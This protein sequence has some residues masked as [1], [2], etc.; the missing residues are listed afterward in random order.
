[1]QKMITG[2]PFGFSAEND[3][4]Y[5]ADRAVYDIYPEDAVEICDEKYRGLRCKIK[6]TL[7]FKA[8]IV[9]KN[10]KNIT[11]DFRGAKIVMHGKIQPFLL[12]GAENITI[13]NCS[14]TAN[15]PPYTETRI[16]EKTEDRVLLK[17]NPRCTCRI[18]DGELIPYGDGW[19]NHNL[20]RG[21]M[22][23]Q[24]FDPVTAEDYGYILGACGK[25]FR[26]V[27][28]RPWRPSFFHV[29]DAGDG[30]LTLTGP[31]PEFF[32]PGCILNI[33]HEPRNL[34]S[35]YA[36]DCKDLTIENY[37]ILCGTGMGLFLFRTENITVDG[38][39]LFHDEA[40][41]CVVTNAAD[42]FH[43]FACTGTIT[44]KNSVFENMVDDAI[45]IHGNFHTVAAAEDGA[46]I[47]DRG[48][49][50]EEADFAFGVG[51]T[52]AV[53]RGLTMEETARYTVKAIEDIEE[54]KQR[55]IV[56]GPVRNHQ[57]GDL[58]ENLS[59][60]A[61]VTIENCRFGKAISNL[62][63]QN[64]GK[65]ILKNCECGLPVQL[66]GDATFWFESGPMQDLLI[67]GC[68]FTRPQATVRIVPEVL[69]T[70]Q[71][72]YYHEN[73]RI[74]NCTFAST[75]PVEGW[76]ANNLT[77]TGNKQRDGLP[78]TLKLADCG[79]VNAE[80]CTVERST[81]KDETLNI[82]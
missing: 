58:V 41:P 28:A 22:F 19:E 11:L 66:T 62:R 48:S 25:A 5:V 69:A 14:V 20:D 36:I 71:A 60:Y 42:A 73:I 79:T 74:E 56:D 72:P 12:D 67:A 44:I 63:L 2:I 1:M 13:K 18:E 52:I 32:Q 80:N 64:R 46:L 68:T 40:S 59:G 81:R 61:D 6:A 76:M 7:D 10:K 30:C 65:F 26:P 50:E 43:T 35:V 9:L 45:N 78:M 34:A 33:S 8:W 38:Y 4:L 54:G 39:R 70:E 49:C 51:D 3:S 47:L 29:E 16:L 55:F 82:N 77:F 23:Y 53:Y 17:T 31:I 75:V 24:V 21:G 27:P 57:K 37:R 15:R